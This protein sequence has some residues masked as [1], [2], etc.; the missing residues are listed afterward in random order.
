LRKSLPS[1][2]GAAARSSLAVLRPPVVKLRAMTTG[3][4][5][6]L[7]LSLSLVFLAVLASGSIAQASQCPIAVSNL[8]PM[9]DGKHYAAIMQSTTQGAAD[10][11]LSLYSD[12]ATYVVTFPIVV[13]DRRLADLADGEVRPR[14]FTAAPLFF[15]LPQTDAL[16]AARTDIVSAAAAPVCSPEY[17]YSTV[18]EQ[19]L[20][21]K[22]MPSAAA[23][24]ESQVLVQL[25]GRVAAANAA[26][27]EANAKLDCD[28]QYG[29][30][31][32]DKFAR[33][34]YPE[35]LAN[36]AAGTALVGV[37]LTSSGAIENVSLLRSAGNHFLDLAALK[38]AA[39]SIYRPEYFRCQPTG[40]RYFLSIRLS[41]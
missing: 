19:R 24:S 18:L 31:K 13:F 5:V 1:S 12:G 20:D 2:T 38:S 26:L 16:L 8:V 33:P 17:R 41:P 39:G 36:H 6:R 29:K 15:T 7:G 21:A 23:V 4:Y 27:V 35:T 11:R 30:A 32:L 37:D 14:P 28:E 9:P 10:L 40:G 3:R 34:F 22:F 25:F